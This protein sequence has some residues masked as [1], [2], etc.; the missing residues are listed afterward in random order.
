MYSAVAGV[1]V[2]AAL[3]FLY[4]TFFTTPATCFDGIQNGDEIG[5]DCGGSCSLMCA[6]QI[7]QPSVAW[8]R[9]FL[10]TTATSSPDHQKHTYT[11]AAY[12]TNTNLDSGAHNVKYSFQLRDANNEL[13][14]ERRGTADIPPLPT[15]PIVETNIDAGSRVVAHT[16]FTFSELPA[17]NRIPVD[18]IPQVTVSNQ[19]L[20]QDGTKL[21]LTLNNPTVRDVSNV[22]VVGILYDADGAAIAASKSFVSSIEHKGS[23]DVVFTWPTPNP[24]VVRAEIVVLPSF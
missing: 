24:D 12:I 5:T 6:S 20:A 22:T 15:V 13:I 23:Q 3:V 4:S 1:I 10:T 8:A 14:I 18:G 9:S 16:L 2:L 7:K 11:A 19:L 21:S 17:W